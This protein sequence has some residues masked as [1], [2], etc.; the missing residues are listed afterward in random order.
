MLFDVGMVRFT[1]PFV[2]LL[3]K[4]VGLFLI[5]FDLVQKTETDKISIWK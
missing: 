3:N 5:R 2:C 4:N 1:D